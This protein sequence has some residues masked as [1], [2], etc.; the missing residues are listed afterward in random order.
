MVLMPVAYRRQFP[1]D[2]FVQIDNVNKRGWNGTD[3]LRACPYTIVLV[4]IILIPVL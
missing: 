1:V 3:M 2:A 4:E